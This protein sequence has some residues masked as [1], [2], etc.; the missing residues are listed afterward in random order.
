[1]VVKVRV[2]HNSR[3]LAVR[4]NTGRLLLCAWIAVA[5]IGCY[6]LRYH[7]LVLTHVDL[8][9][10]FAAATLPQL[11]AAPDAISPA[12]VERLRYPLARARQFV[13]LAAKRFPESEARAALAR[14]T[15]VYAGLV[16]ELE[17]I[18]AGAGEAS[19]AIAD[20]AAVQAAANRVREA[21]IDEIEDS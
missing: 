14:M 8:L 12:D 16:E 10:D 13:D 15:E 4:A 11:E 9:E 19:K 5:S 21:V 17:R 3:V 7:D 20:V 18:R 2:C 1:V 6:W